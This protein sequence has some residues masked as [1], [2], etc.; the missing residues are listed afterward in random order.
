M[1]RIPPTIMPL[2]G[3]L[4]LHN[5][6]AR[7][8]LLYQLV[9]RDFEKRYIGSFGGWTWGVIQPLVLLLSWVFVFQICFRVQPQGALAQNYPLYL[10]SAQLPWMLF[11]DSLSR[12]TPSFVDN[13]NFIT[14]TVFPVESI[15]LSIFLSSCVQHLLGMAVLIVATAIWERHVNAFL[16]LLIPSLFLLALFSVGLSWILASLHVF[17][18]DTAQIVNVLLTFWFWFTP[19][20][21]EEQMV[22][23]SLRFII[24]FNP[25]AYFVGIYRQCVLGDGAPALLQFVIAAGFAVVTFIAGG[26]FFRRLRRGFADVL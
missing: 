24:H 26:F 21:I 8:E 3:S 18:R 16:P 22:P 9:R 6:V 13:R 5:L 20:F 12:S 15:P 14:K 1:G 11:S 7:R 17:L 2:P 10:F 25:M 4:F 19:I 23:E